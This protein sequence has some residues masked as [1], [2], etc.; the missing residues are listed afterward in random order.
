MKKFFKKVKMLSF[1]LRKF[2][3]NFFITKFSILSLKN[4]GPREQKPPAGSWSS[5]LRLPSWLIQLS[6]SLA[7]TVPPREA[8]LGHMLTARFRSF[9]LFL[10]FSLH[11]SRPTCLLH[12]FQPEDGTW[13][14]KVVQRLGEDRSRC[15]DV[16]K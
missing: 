3:H 6:L 9:C 5:G 10:L 8:L 13:A 2:C 16:Q 11:C 15:E 7:V 14:E 1:T 12:T 4:S